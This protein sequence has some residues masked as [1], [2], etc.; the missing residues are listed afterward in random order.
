[1]RTLVSLLISSALVLLTLVGCDDDE[2]HPRITRLHASETCGVAPLR[3]DFRVDATG[4]AAEDEATGVNNWINATWDFGDGTT[5]S[6]GTSV[7]YHTYSEPALY[8]VVCTVE[9]ADGL[10]D[11]DSM[12]VLVRA[13]SLS[14]D[15]RGLL[16]GAPVDQVETCRPL[17]LEMVGS[18]CTFDPEIDNPDRFV[19]TWQVGDST[20]AAPRP[21]HAFHPDVLE[22]GDGE[23]QVVVTVFD[24]A[25]DVFRSDSASVTVVA[26]E[27]A[28]LTVDATWANTPENPADADTLARVVESFPDTLIYT[29]IARNDGLADGYHVRLRGEFPQDDG[30]GNTNVRLEH[31]RG[32]PDAGAYEYYPED[33]P[34]DIDAF[35]T[36]DIPVFPGGSETSLD[37]VVLFER[38][39]KYDVYQFPIEIDDYW[40]DASDADNTALSQVRI[41]SAPSD[42]LLRT[43]WSQTFQ[44][45]NLAPILLRQVPADPGYPDTVRYTMQVVNN[46]PSAAFD[47]QV[48]GSLD[49]DPRVTWAD[50]IEITGP[51][52]TF[53]Y[54][55]ATRSWTWGLPAVSTIGN[56]TMTLIIDEAPL[57]TAFEFPATLAP[58]AEDPTGDD[59]DATAVYQV[60]TALSDLSLDAAWF[61][62]DGNQLSADPDLD[63]DVLSFPDD[64]MVRYTVTNDG[65]YLARDLGIDGQISLQ[66]DARELIDDATAF[67]VVTAAG[68]VEIDL[69]RGT[70]RWDFPELAVGASVTLDLGF[71]FELLDAVS[72]EDQPYR[73]R[74]QLDPYPGDGSPGNDNV[75]SQLWIR[76]LPEK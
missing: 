68:E 3:V 14:V 1:M 22:D 55:P 23:E 74:A 54:D 39:D 72:P 56:L 11:T 46:G 34:N 45:N 49:D 4:G 44:P 5:V 20:Y 30:Q 43:N 63:H 41:A 61:D 57:D 32:E 8:T 47:L 60:Y 64:L 18:S 50:D 71:L 42:L 6:G 19:F 24:P 75:T 48:T 40:C 37:I 10:S 28:D 26:S 65:P 53:D 25:Y 73:L 76:S 13:D 31:V 62:Q 66:D 21:A 36:W 58:Y 70:W 38:A 7:A 35:W 59:H 33:A 17:E 52:D 12:H 9:D 51:D 69:A 29:V 15:I 27:G 16:D 67:Q 2:V